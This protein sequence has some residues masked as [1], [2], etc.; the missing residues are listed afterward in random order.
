MNE[1]QK[2]VVAELRAKPEYNPASYASN[3]LESMTC[4]GGASIVVLLVLS[5]LGGLVIEFGSSL[6]FART[7]VTNV[8][9]VVIVPVWTTTLFTILWTIAVFWFGNKKIAKTC[10]M[11]TETR[12]SWFNEELKKVGIDPLTV[13]PER[14]EKIIV[15]EEEKKEA[16][17]PTV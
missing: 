15:A 2:K 13:A 7:D 10:A 11:H 17:P 6:L 8:A 9:D 12:D 14:E 3:K 1:E 5:L 4:Y 16:T